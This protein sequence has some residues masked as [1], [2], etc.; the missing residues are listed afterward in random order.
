MR[1]CIIT[2]GQFRWHFHCGQIDNFARRNRSILSSDG[3]FFSERV[4][5]VTPNFTLGFSI[6]FLRRLFFFFLVSVCRV[7]SQCQPQARQYGGEGLRFGFNHQQV[8]RAHPQAWHGSGDPGVVMHQANDLGI[9]VPDHFY[10]LRQG[11]ADG[12]TLL[13]HKCFG[14]V[15]ASIE[16][17]GPRLGPRW[18]QAPADQGNEQHAHKGHNHAYGRKV[19]HPVTARASTGA[20]AG[21]DQV[22]GRADQ[23]GHAA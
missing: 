13:A 2:P 17:S 19:E 11:F 3:A 9:L 7:C 20:K 1:R 18:H 21:Y 23:G 10:Q 4:D 5:L 12:G 8:A 14:K 16:G 15:T 22:G 6:F